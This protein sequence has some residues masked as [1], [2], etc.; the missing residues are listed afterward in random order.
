[1]PNQLYN[2][3]G[4]FVYLDT[5]GLDSDEA[6]IKLAKDPNRSIN[7]DGVKL[8]GGVAYVCSEEDILAIFLSGMT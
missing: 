4:L 2:R 8:D 6:T 3:P 1:M 7:H 5:V